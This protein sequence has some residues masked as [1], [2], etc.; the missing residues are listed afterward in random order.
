MQTETENKLDRRFHV[1]GL[2]L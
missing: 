2:E 1:R